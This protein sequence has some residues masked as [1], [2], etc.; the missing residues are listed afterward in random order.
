[1]SRPKKMIQ[2]DIDYCV[3]ERAPL[4]QLDVIS[5]LLLDIRQLLIKI[6]KIK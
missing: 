5:E 1:M 3:N 6:S 2:G 4:E